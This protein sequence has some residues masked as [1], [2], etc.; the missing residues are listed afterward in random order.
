MATSSILTNVK[1]TDPHKAELFVS[2]LEASS[3]DPKWTPTAEVKPP[4]T[5]RKA[6]RDLVFKGQADKRWIMK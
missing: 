2:A 5:D 1:I 4:L 3:K 6:I